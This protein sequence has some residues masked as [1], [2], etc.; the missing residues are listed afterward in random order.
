MAESSACAVSASSPQSG[1]DFHGGPAPGTDLPHGS[2][3]IDPTDLPGH[4]GPTWQQQWQHVDPNHFAPGA[5]WAA[6]AGQ[7]LQHAVPD[8]IPPW[9]DAH[10]AFP[11]A[12][13]HPSMATQPPMAILPPLAHHH[14]ASPHACQQYDSQGYAPAYS[15]LYSVSPPHHP[16]T[17]SP[18]GT[19]P[20]S[21]RRPQA[22]RS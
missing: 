15:P 6:A 4:M 20:P 7:Q 3:F 8:A 9:S 11:A 13:V 14:L 16:P 5:Q 19:P 2:G 1:T 10:G 12:P 21:A 17:Q 18:W 22:R